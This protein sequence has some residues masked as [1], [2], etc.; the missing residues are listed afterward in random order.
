MK[1]R[2]W[3]KLSERWIKEK[4]VT[5]KIEKLNLQRMPLENK[6]KK[7]HPAL[8]LLPSIFIEEGDEYQILYIWTS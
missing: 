6:T 4:K 5:G 7:R 2:L 8:S 1:R 3:K